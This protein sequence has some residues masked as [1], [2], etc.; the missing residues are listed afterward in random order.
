[1]STKQ[2]RI[3]EDEFKLDRF[4]NMPFS[5]FLNYFFTWIPQRD[6]NKALENY[7]RDDLEKQIIDNLNNP[8]KLKYLSD[9]I[10]KSLWLDANRKAKLQKLGSLLK[11]EYHVDN[12]MIIAYHKKSSYKSKFACQTLSYIDTDYAIQKS[13]EYGIYM[14]DNKNLLE[15]LIIP[16]YA[17]H[18]DIKGCRDLIF[19]IV[20]NNIYVGSHKLKPEHVY[21]K[22]CEENIEDP[23]I[24]QRL[25]SLYNY[26]KRYEIKIIKLLH[27]FRN[28][29]EV[30][31]K[32]ICKVQN[33]GSIV[34][35]NLLK[36][37]DLNINIDSFDDEILENKIFVLL[38]QH[39]FNAICYKLKC[40]NNISS[41]NINHHKLNIVIKCIESEL[42]VIIKHLE[43]VELLKNRNAEDYCYGIN[44]LGGFSDNTFENYY[45]PLI[46]LCFIGQYTTSKETFIKIMEVINNT[47]VPDKYACQQIYKDLNKN[48]KFKGLIDSKY[49]L[50]DKRN[51]I[52]NRFSL[53]SN[54]SLFG[55]IINDKVAVLCGMIDDSILNR[56]PEKELYLRYEIEEIYSQ[57]NRWCLSKYTKCNITKIETYNK[58]E[59]IKELEKLLGL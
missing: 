17:N 47:L 36:K 15:C 20:E 39:K 32:I 8:E 43:N 12:M 30:K 27:P 11:T 9:L 49:I 40:Y 42:D 37:L 54:N 24:R 41:G 53:H 19:R 16:L 51:Y 38:Q 55:I 52:Y 18:M 56:K 34:L 10:S 31:E 57:E 1:M 50:N 33:E 58:T 4:L 25:I 22:Y 35:K 59:R 21:F 29:P 14:L 48:Q 46:C 13:I 5:D 28:D 3:T 23:L 7:K 26:N 45:Y 6:L 44:P 2:I